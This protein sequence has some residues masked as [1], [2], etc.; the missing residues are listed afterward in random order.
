MFLFI[1]LL[2]LFFLSAGVAGLCFAL[3]VKNCAAR[4]EQRQ[5]RNIELRAHARG[6]LGPPDR[7]ATAFGVRVAGGLLALLSF[8]LILAPVIAAAAG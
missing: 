6:D 8:G 3:N 5:L 1:L 2:L 4:F 7:I